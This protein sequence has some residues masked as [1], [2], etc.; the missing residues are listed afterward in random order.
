M[1]E[2]GMLRLLNKLWGN[3]SRRRRVQAYLILLLSIFVSILEII[4][5]GAALP[6][7]TVITDPGKLVNLSV[8]SYFDKYI[9]S[10]TLQKTTLIITIVFCITNILTGVLRVVLMWAVSKFSFGIGSEISS[11]I[12]SKT[13]YQPYKVH[14]SRNTA[15]VISG[16]SAKSSHVIHGAI[17]PVF[18]MVTSFFILIFVF[19]GLILINPKIALSM[20]GGFAVIY[21]LILV[22]T[23][24]RLTRDSYVVSYQSEEYLKA[25]QHGL[26]GIRDILIDG[27]QEIFLEIYRKADLAFRKAESSSVFI[28]LSPRYLIES[29]G[30]VL[31]ATVAYFYTSGDLSSGQNSIG[32]LP[33]LGVLAIGAQRLLPLL[34]QIYQSISKIRSSKYSL[35]DT[36]KLLDQP[37]QIVLPYSDAPDITF[38]SEIRLKD[39]SFSY[40]NESAPVLENVSIVIPKGSIVGIVGETGSGKSTLLDILMGLL[41]PSSGVMYV[42]DLM[43]D[44][45]GISSWAKH[46]SHVPQSI[47]LVDGTIEENIAFGIKSE[48]INLSKVREC[49]K[50][51]CLEEFIESLPMKYKNRVGER[52]A[53]ISGGQRQRIGIARALYKGG[54]VIIL[55]EATSAL[56]A[57][58]EDVV[59]QNIESLQR[60]K[61]L[62]I[63]A[64]RLN[65][66]KNCHFLINI[67]KGELIKVNQKSRSRI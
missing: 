34:Q 58:T 36:L 20:F 56:D 55:D 57:H 24:K 48:N 4:S 3:F 38:N 6:F 64:H 9:A 27:T 45:D 61:T 37:A 23:K 65:T 14:I 5:I 19:F 21:G 63:V 32:V 30:V 62:V 59:M 66:L 29:M 44:I 42:D 54:D 11:S 2:Q 49:A 18:N 51:A 43:I 25:L 52:G 22:L 41:N 40:S 8:M 16:V 35:I 39:V 50:L 47:F 31:M 1:N 46:I 26:G 7:L 13:L 53:Q 10:F 33:L 12:F 67:K 28:G 15:E 60:D 17:L